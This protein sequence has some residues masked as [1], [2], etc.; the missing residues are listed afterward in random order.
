MSSAF[1]NATSTGVDAIDCIAR[2]EADACGVVLTVPVTARGADAALGGSS[3]AEAAPTT[4]GAALATTG[5]PSTAAVTRVGWVSTS[6]YVPTGTGYSTNLPVTASGAVAFTGL[7]A[8]CADT[9][10]AAASDGSTKPS[11]VPTLMTRGITAIT[12]FRL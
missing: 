8:F 7:P 6:A 10:A 5:T 4:V 9:R 1:V 12:G 3:G 11:M 2:T